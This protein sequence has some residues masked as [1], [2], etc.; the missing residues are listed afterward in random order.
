RLLVVWPGRR[1][2]AHRARALGCQQGLS[3]RRTGILHGSPRRTAG[4]RTG[5]IMAAFGDYVDLHR[6]GPGRAKLTKLPVGKALLRQYPVFVHWA[7]LGLLRGIVASRG[8][9]SFAYK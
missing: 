9:G 6:R 8:V 4:G 7:V 5:R 1:R 3:P 2:V